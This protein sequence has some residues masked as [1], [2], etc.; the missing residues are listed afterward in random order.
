MSQRSIS[1]ITLLLC[2]LAVSQLA[3]AQEA[4]LNGFDDYVQKAMRD[5]E[6][7]RLAIAILKDDKIVFS[8]GYGV[9]RLGG[10]GDL[11]TGNYLLIVIERTTW[12]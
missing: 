12:R 6:V 5:W 10:A 4:P 11:V 2:V 7:H 1:L 3:R 9:R 8:K